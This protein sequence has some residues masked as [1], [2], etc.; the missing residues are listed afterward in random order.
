MMDVDYLHLM[1]GQASICYSGARPQLEVTDD[2]HTVSPFEVRKE[3]VKRFAVKCDAS[4]LTP[5]AWWG[6]YC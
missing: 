3:L 6:E 4:P 1:E 5:R 2:P